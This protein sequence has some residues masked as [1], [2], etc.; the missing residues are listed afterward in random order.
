MCVP[1][2]VEIVEPTI[3]EYLKK[4]EER[5]RLGAAEAFFDGGVFG[6]EPG[7]AIATG[8]GDFDGNGG[9]GRARESKWAAAD[10]YAL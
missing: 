2:G 5:V 8:M 4:G 9:G 7:V 10:S 6:R 3:E 1:P